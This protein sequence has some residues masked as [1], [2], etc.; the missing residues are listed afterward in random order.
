[1]KR[2]GARGIENGL[3]KCGCSGFGFTLIELLVVVAIIALLIGILLPSLSGARDSAKRV[4]TKAIMKSAGDGLEFFVDDNTK[5]LKG[6]SY[7]S[8]APDADQTVDGGG[9]QMFGA[10]H[11][12]RYLMGKDGRGWVSPS[13]VPRKYWNDVENYQQKGWYD[14]PGDP[15]FPAGA[16]EPFARSGPYLQPEAVRTRRIMDI[17][18]TAGGALISEATAEPQHRN[19]VMVDPYDKPILYYAANSRQA[20]KPDAPIATGQRQYLPYVTDGYSAIYDFGDNAL[21]T[22]G[23]ACGGGECMCWGVG[24]ALDFGGGPSELTWPEA[25][26]TTEPEWKDVIETE[27]KSFAYFIMNKDLFESTEGKAVVPNRRDS[28]IMLSPGKD[29]VFGTRDDVTNFD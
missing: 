21:F 29:G 6:N 26:K 17:A 4:K 9:M 2:R 18:T 3:S 25:W 12:V 27:P 10:Q 19:P 16:T 7:P 8:S 22:T 24:D 1:M 11:L 13:S 23:C 14:M 28:F 15:D 5:A 20:A